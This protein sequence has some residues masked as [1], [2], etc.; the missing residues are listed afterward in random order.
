VGAGKR[1][2]T[3]EPFEFTS[4]ELTY[5]IV[6]SYSVAFLGYFLKGQ[7]E[8]GSFLSENHWPDTMI[9]DVKGMAEK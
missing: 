8:Y 2:E 5:Q 1:R 3:N 7:K 4:M 9:W 6:N